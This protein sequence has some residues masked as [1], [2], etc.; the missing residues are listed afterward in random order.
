VSV[1]TI[2]KAK[3]NLARLIEK[4]E[5]CEDIVIARGKQPV[6]RLVPIVRHAGKRPFGLFKGK[7]KFD[8]DFFAPLPKG[9]LDAWEAW[10]VC[11][12]PDTPRRSACR[13]LNIVSSDR[14]ST[15][16]ASAGSGE[17]IRAS[18]HYLECDSVSH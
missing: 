3:S 10:P 11:V 4:A 6:V 5:R 2:R 8:A 12:S 15:T 7:Y 16:I 9:E 18:G 1:T 14:I 13:N 17:N